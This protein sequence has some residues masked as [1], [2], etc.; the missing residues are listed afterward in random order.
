MKTNSKFQKIILA[1]T[2]VTIPTISLPANALEAGLVS[3]APKND[4][5]LD[6]DSADHSSERKEVQDLLDTV[7]NQWNSHNLDALMSNYSD[8]YVNNDGLNKKAVT[9]LTKDFWEQYPDAKSASK[10]KE[11]RI[12]ANYATVDSR[13]V[14]SGTTAKEITGI[15]GKGE[16]H[17]VSEGQLYLR[18]FADG[19]KIIGDRIDYE[20]VKVAY[21]LAKQMDTFFVAPEQ[22]KAGKK[23]SA[24][25]EIKLPT[26]LV[27]VGEITSQNLRYP[28][29]Q[30]VFPN[31]PATEI[32]KPLD[33]NALQKDSYILERIMEANTTNHNELLMTTLGIT[34]AARNSLVGLEFLTRRMNIVPATTDEPDVEV[35]KGAEKNKDKTAQETGTNKGAEQANK[36][37]NQDNTSKTESKKSGT[38]AP[39]KPAIKHNFVHKSKTKAQL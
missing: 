32:W 18:K 29:S 27:A 13:D 38:A 24:K 6:I 26:G 7:E 9:D 3:S 37:G 25:L 15:N 17:S 19:W 31:S 35:A 30:A 5:L 21:G 10:T 22:V 2:L 39:A 20:K 36:Q 1:M 16:L 11:I 34:N 28:S 14:A 8:D 33:P 23:Y 12:E 4:F